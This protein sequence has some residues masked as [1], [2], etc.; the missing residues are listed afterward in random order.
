M[1]IDR[2]KKRLAELEQSAPK[3]LIVR[4]INKDETEEILTAE[5]LI[6]KPCKDYQIVT[7][8][9]GNNM[10]DFKRVLDWEHQGLECA[11]EREVAN[12]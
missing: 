5:E 10:S 8:V 7:V 4:Y 6:K 9:S 3:S 1:N 11:I 2:L 12:D